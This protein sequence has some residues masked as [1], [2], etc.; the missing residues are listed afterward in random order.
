[1]VERLDVKEDEKPAE[2]RRG[3]DQDLG[4]IRWQV[5][6]G[7]NRY[8]DIEVE[9]GAPAWWVGDEEASNASLDAMRAMGA[10]I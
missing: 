3:F 6:G 5:P 9:E 1:M 8:A 7:S 4:V 10:K 2:V